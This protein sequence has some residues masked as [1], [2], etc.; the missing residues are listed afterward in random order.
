MLQSDHEKNMPFIDFV[1]DVVEQFSECV[2]SYTI[3]LI[4]RFF[5]IKTFSIF[6]NGWYLRCMFSIYYK[7]LLHQP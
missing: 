1:F 2:A 3:Y 4:V 5:D 6:D 7:T